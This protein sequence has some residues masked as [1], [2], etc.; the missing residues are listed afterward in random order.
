MYKISSVHHFG[1]GKTMETLKRAVFAGVGWE[2]M[3]RLGSQD[4]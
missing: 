4:F 3:H 2:S 1:K